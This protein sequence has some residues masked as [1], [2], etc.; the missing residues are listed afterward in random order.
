MK[1]T[2][3][4]IQA[5]NKNRVN[6]SVDGAYRFSLDVFQVGEL[7][8][9]TGKEYSEEELIALE[10]ESQ[11]G[12]LYARAMEYCLMR[13]HSAREVRDYLYRKTRTTKVKS[14]TT[15]EVSDRPGVSQEIA[16]RVFD[17]LS[18]KG[19]VDDEKFARFWI[20]NRKQRTGISSRKLSAELMAKG[21]ER[22]IIEQL[23]KSSDRNDLDELMKTIERKRRKY[24]D[25]NKLIAYLLR[26]GYGYDDVKTAIA[27]L[28]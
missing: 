24:D 15:G 25:E 27:S 28:E 8:L 7:G 21:V 2:S 19:Y 17:R 9:K 20:E 5:K 11:F 10:T 4:A 1:I 3:I 18:E 22:G 6:V 13:P 14:R 16:T 12:K 23:T 26:Q